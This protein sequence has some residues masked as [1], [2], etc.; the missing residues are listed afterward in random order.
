MRVIDSRF[1]PELNIM[2]RRRRCYDCDHVFETTERI[3]HK[4]KVKRRKENI[5]KR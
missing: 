3:I 5:V 1:D 4:K 2:I